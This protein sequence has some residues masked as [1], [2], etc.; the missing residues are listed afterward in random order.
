MGCDLCL[1]YV[2]KPTIWQAYLLSIHLRCLSCFICW[3]L[4]LKTMNQERMDT[5]LLAQPRLWT[6]FLPQKSTVFTP[7]FHGDCINT[8][9][10]GRPLAWRECWHRSTQE[11][12]QELT[13]SAALILSEVGGAWKGTDM[14]SATRQVLEVAALFVHFLLATLFSVQIQR[15]NW[16]S[17]KNHFL[18]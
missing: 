18:T 16:Y 14:G 13:G 5:D 2:F 9:H 3:S 6:R 15:Y 8:G 11:A 10:Q 12:L 4:D 7:R 17:E 1:G